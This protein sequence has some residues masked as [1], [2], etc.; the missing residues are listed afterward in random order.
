MATKKKNTN[1]KNT[2]QIHSQAKVEFYK[3]Y[4]KR[5]LRILNL[6]S[7]INNINIYDVLCGMGIYEDGGKGSPIVAF[8]AIKELSN[9]QSLKNI[10]LVVNDKNVK[11]IDVIK[12]YIDCQND[13]ICNMRYFNKDVDEMFKIVVGEINSFK[14]DTRNLIFIDPYGYKRIR[15]ETIYALMKSKKTEIILFLPISH[16]HRFTQA[17]VNDD[18]TKQYKPLRDF[19][20]S[21]FDENHIIRTDKTS[22]LD[23]INYIK[24]ALRFNDEFF[25]SS[26]FIERDAVNKFALFFISFHRYGYEKILEVKWLLDDDYGNGF[27]RPQEPGLFDEFEKEESQLRTKEIVKKLIWNALITP[28]TN[29]ELYLL[30]LNNEFLPTHGTRVLKELQC[31]ERIEVF[32]IEKNKVARKG[33]FYIGW[34]Y[35]NNNK[36]SDKVRIARKV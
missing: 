21:F 23:Y 29:K 18:I 35:F 9:E 31:E 28:K 17:A 14:S 8:D 7:Y 36:C 19:V 27:R 12:N 22:V 4:I 6:A 3:A 2:L 20:F 15:K 5:Y 25:T 33:S 24:V 10:S 34:N 16:M 11:R 26:Y 1:V 13:Q 32:D 30:L